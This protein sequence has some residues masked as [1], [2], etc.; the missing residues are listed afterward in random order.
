[1]RAGRLPRQAWRHAPHPSCARNC[2]DITVSDARLC[3]KRDSLGAF[4]GLWLLRRVPSEVRQRH[5][6]EDIHRPFRLFAAD[7][8][9]RGEDFLPAWRAAARP[10]PPPP[11]LCV[12][13][14]LRRHPLPLLIASAQSAEVQSFTNP[15]LMQ[16][17]S[18]C[19][20]D[21]PACLTRRGRRLAVL[22]L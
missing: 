16:T 20:L 17:F 4:A 14:A 8:L 1:M 2:L 6:L 13:T 22:A 10:A 12:R 18:R 21:S 9:H 7:S 19:G 11:P 5:R 15:L 3:S